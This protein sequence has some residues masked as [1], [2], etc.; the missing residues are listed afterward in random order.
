MNKQTLTIGEVSKELGRVAHTIRQWE[1]DK[2]LP[3]ELLPGRDENGWRVWSP[4]Q[5]EGLKK[6]IEE[7]DLRPGKALPF[8][9]GIL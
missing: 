7:S 6:W 2:R 3:I 5:V 8:N 4:D 1:R 9:K